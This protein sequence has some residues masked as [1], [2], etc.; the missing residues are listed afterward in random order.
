MLH[1]VLRRMIVLI[2]AVA[3]IAVGLGIVC[4]FALLIGLV[5]E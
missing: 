2:D 5:L 1:V 4:A 3:A